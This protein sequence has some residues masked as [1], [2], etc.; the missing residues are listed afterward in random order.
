MFGDMSDSFKMIGT[1][2]AQIELRD[3]RTGEDDVPD[4]VA[5]GW[6]ERDIEAREGL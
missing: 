5:R 2:V 3:N 6:P 1:V 4:P